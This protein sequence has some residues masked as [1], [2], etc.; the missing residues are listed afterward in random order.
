[1]KAESEWELA[2]GVLVGMGMI[3]EEE[4]WELK[5]EMGMPVWEWWGNSHTAL[6]L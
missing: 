5:W 3:W 2:V 6:Q 4:S 1:M